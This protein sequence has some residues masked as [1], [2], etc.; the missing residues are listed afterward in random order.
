M[1]IIGDV[2]GKWA[3]YKKI[4]DQR[5]DC[6]VQVGDMGIGFGLYPDSFQY[7]HRFIRGNHDN[8][9]VCERH[10]NYLGDFG[11]FNGVFYASGA[12]SIDQHLRTPNIDWWRDEELS[13]AKAEECIDYFK[14]VRPEVVVSHDC[15]ESV[16]SDMFGIKDKSF[17]RTFLQNMLDAWNPDVWVFGHHHKDKTL[18]RRTEFVCLGELSTV[19]IVTKFVPVNHSIS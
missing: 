10:P 7:S 16:A 13:Y 11:V 2:H 19:E 3:E 8:P 17:T 4:I 6:T 1:L 15:P 14:F 5:Q 18:S 12:K 9:T